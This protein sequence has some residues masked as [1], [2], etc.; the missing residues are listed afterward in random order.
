[1]GSGASTHHAGSAGAALEVISDAGRVAAMLS[2]MRRRILGSLREPDSASGLARRF[3]VPRQKVNYHIRR[4]EAAGL[5][6]CVERRQ[7]RGCVERRLRL[8]A[9]A[10]VIDPAVIE[11]LGV[12]PDAVQDRFSSS[13]LMAAASRVVRE[14]ST[15][16]AGAASARRKLPTLTLETEVALA[17][18]A[19][20]AAFAGELNDSIARLVTRYHQPSAP[21][22]RLYRF[23]LGGHPAITRGGGGTRP[24]VPSLPPIPRKAGPHKRAKRG[25]STG[26]EKK[27]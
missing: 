26:K 19:D 25:T 18:P 5:I 15:L 3:G 21:A 10:F 11:G 14:I 4:L 22:G 2:P 8:T 27:P 1:M 9:R 6:E 24:K 16:R 17:S 20:L 13:Y 7:R 23:I 12:D